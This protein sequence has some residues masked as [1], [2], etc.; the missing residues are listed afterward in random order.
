MD[1]RH[2]MG[3]QQAEDHTWLQTQGA[4]CRKWV[5]DSEVQ[6]HRAQPGRE[7]DRSQVKTLAPSA[8]LDFG[9]TMDQ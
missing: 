7:E 6:E 1:S 4:S 9:I 3:R 8:Q 5:D 2:P